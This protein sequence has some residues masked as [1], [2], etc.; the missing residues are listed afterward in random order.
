[1]SQPALDKMIAIADA[2]DRGAFAGMDRVDTDTVAELVGL[3]SKSVS[4]LLNSLK[5][6]Q[7]TP[8]KS[9][10]ERH[11]RVYE[12]P[13]RI[14]LPDAKKIRQPE[15]RLVVE[16]IAD[17]RLPR[18]LNTALLYHRLGQSL[19]DGTT[20]PQ[21][22]LPP[23]L[24]K[25]LLR[26]GFSS[27]RPEGF[28]SKRIWKP[29]TWAPPQDNEDWP[30]VFLEQRTLRRNGVRGVHHIPNH[31]RRRRVGRYHPEGDGTVEPI[32]HPL[33]PEGSIEA[34]DSC[35]YQRGIL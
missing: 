7:L 31:R 21:G 4:R 30:A 18:R 32:P 24:H 14:R 13:P 19:N 16:T 34:T 28:K 12:Y 20:G 11:D 2:F 22:H 25:A 10:K 9:V 33:R 35:G 15:A 17:Q 3:P 1:M 5:V 23:P 29:A 26:S 8:A 6:R 27:H